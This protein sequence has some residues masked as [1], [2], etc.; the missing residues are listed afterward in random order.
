MSIARFS[1]APGALSALSGRD[2]DRAHYIFLGDLSQM[3]Q[4]EMFLRAHGFPVVKRDV[5]PGFAKEH[6]E[7][8]VRALKLVFEHRL[9]GWWNQEEAL[10]EHGVCTKDEFH[11]ILHSR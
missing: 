10:I 3:G 4:I 2:D 8:Y 7:T 5:H 11:A 6:K 1:F 9:D